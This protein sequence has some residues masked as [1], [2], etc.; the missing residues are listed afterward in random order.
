LQATVFGFAPAQRVPV[1]VREQPAA[2]DEV[3]VNTTVPPAADKLVGLSVSNAV[4]AG[5]DGARRDRAGE[6]WNTTSLCA[7]EALPLAENLKTTRTLSWDRLGPIE[8]V[9]RKTPF[10]QGR[11]RQLK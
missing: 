4:G 10:E 5:G 2:F 1:D 11:E 9:S 3:Y 8:I 7:T 6:T